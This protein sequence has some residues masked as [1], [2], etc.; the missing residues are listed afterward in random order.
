MALPPPTID[1]AVLVTGA[2]SGI[3][4]ALAR[5]LAGR[6]YNLVLV[7]RREEPMEVLAGELRGEHGVE[8]GVDSTDLADPG[9]RAE[10]VRRLEG[11]EREVVGV[12]NSAGFGSVGRFADLPLEREQAAIRVNVEALHHLTGAF[13]GR[14]VEQG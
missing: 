3:G 7:A 2:S 1:S 14:M 5:E 8:I 13:L 11:G 10:L 4:E 12:C 6:S 9:A